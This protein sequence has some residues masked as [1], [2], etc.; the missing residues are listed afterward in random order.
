MPRAH[1]ARLLFGRRSSASGSPDS[2]A[3]PEAARAEPVVAGA[4]DRDHAAGEEVAGRRA[5]GRR[6]AR[7]S[8]PACPGAAGGPC[9]RRSRSPPSGTS[10][11][12]PRCRTGPAAT[13]QSL[14]SKRAHSIESVRIMFSTAARAAPEWTMPGIPWWGERVTLTTLPPPCGMKALVAAAWVICQVPWTFSS[15]TV[16][17]PFGVIASAGLR[18]WPP[19]LLTSTSSR[20][21]RSGSRRRTHPRPR[22]RGCPGL[23][24]GGPARLANLGDRLLE[25]LGA[26][27]AAD[28]GGPQ[29]RELERGRA[30][31][32]G[33][34]PRDRAD[35]PFEQAGREDARTAA[36][37]PSAGAARCYADRR[38]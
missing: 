32:A 7:P 28:D 34:H 24:L 18:N 21:W 13:A 26:A 31:E 33:A 9:G 1:G 3:R 36:A 29:A 38:R 8:P 11:A 27:P 12:A 23:A 4:V 37:R 19:A 25:R 17:K 2:P 16:R 5:P 14:M 35:L 20:P 30:P 15:I 22:H 10:C 6:P